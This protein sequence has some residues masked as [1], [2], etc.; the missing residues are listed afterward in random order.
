[1]ALDVQILVESICVS[2]PRENL[3][4]T[5]NS[6]LYDSA[7]HQALRHLTPWKRFVRD[8]RWRGGPFFC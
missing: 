2:C 7:S 8:R 5:A 3:L 6:F 1:M 4:L